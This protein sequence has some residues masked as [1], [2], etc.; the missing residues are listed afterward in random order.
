ML[1][2]IFLVFY[3]AISVFMLYSLY[4]GLFGKHKECGDVYSVF[5]RLISNSKSISLLTQ[6]VC[7]VLLLLLFYFMQWNKAIIVISFNL[8]FI[9]L[10]HGAYFL[11]AMNETKE[12]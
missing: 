6:V 3:I 12:D 8:S 11:L 4:R 10:M 9:L 1:E 5:C 2:H 7:S